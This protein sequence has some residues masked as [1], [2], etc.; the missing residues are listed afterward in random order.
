VYAGTNL[1]VQLAA[2]F[3]L[4]PPALPEQVYLLLCC[5]LGLGYLLV[6]QLPHG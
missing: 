2:L 5:R 4:S 6:R 3:K 1:V